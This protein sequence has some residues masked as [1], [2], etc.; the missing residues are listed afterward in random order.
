MIKMIFK[1]KKETV[2]CG[3]STTTNSHNACPR[4]KEEGL[5]VKEITIKSQLKKE[6]LNN[7]KLSMSDFNFCSNP[8]CDTV[9][10]SNDGSETYNQ[11]DIKSKVTIKNDNPKTPLCYCR[12]LLKERVLK[13]IEDNESNIYEKIK[14][15][16]SDGKSFCEKSN[17]KGVCCTKDIRNFLIENGVN[18]NEPK[19]QFFSIK[20]PSNCC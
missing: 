11:K 18:L 1:D 10:Y 8:K 20:S 5:A 9:Y 17:P 14:S 3:C 13:M 6:S 19:K 16:I 4:C 7:L 2:G 12:K 15:I